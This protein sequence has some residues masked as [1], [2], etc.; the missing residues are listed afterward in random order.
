MFSRSFLALVTALVWSLFLVSTATAKH[1]PSS[2]CNVY[3]ILEDCKDQVYKITK[4]GKKSLG[5][6]DD[7]LIDEC[8]GM[9]GMIV[10]KC[11]MK[12]LCIN[13]GEK[14]VRRVDDCVRGV[15]PLAKHL[16]P[17]LCHKRRLGGKASF[18]EDV[19]EK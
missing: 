3:D 1:A 12:Y 9:K 11:I 8:Q 16:P 10:A 7:Y 4:K 17:K 13:H 14:A 2:R 6:L 15:C 18:I 19:L 5:E